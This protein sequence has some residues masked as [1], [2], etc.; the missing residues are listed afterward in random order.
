MGE[1]QQTPSAA[2]ESAKPEHV[3]VGIY[4][5]DIQ[6]VDFPTHSYAVDF[7]AWFRW[8]SSSVSACRKAVR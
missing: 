1:P 6:E 7:Y 4:V 2:T 8:K 5:N 3:I